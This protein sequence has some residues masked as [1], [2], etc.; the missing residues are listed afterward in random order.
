MG[1]NSVSQGG[2]EGEGDAAKKCGS[3]RLKQIAEKQGRA[4]R[5]ALSG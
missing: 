3:Q 4:Q 2:G 5:R 1:D